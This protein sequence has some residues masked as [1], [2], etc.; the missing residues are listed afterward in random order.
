MKNTHSI[1]GHLKSVHEETQKQQAIE[2]ELLTPT[3][4]APNHLTLV[5]QWVEDELLN[6][7]EMLRW[8]G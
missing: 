4:Q 1:I 8:G 3:L 7:E 6:C 5:Y 2:K